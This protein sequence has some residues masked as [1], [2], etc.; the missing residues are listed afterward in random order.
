V[1]SDHTVGLR[2]E[3]IPESFIGFDGFA[4][5]ET[6]E[7][8]FLQF[9]WRALKTG[10]RNGLHGGDGSVKSLLSGRIRASVN[11]SLDALFLFWGKLDG[12]ENITHYLNTVRVAA[13][14]QIMEAWLQAVNDFLTLSQLEGESHL[15]IDFPVVGT[16]RTAMQ[17]HH[18]PTQT[19][20]FAEIRR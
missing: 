6:F 7:K 12:H 8:K 10:R 18:H 11:D 1:L 4:G 14:I 19:A 16:R 9:L 20:V 13:E 5:V 3:S 15:Q 17:H 2:R